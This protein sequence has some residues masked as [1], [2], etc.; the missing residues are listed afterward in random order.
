VRSASHWTREAR[1]TDSLGDAIA[2][3]MVVVMMTHPLPLRM[4]VC[5]SDVVNGWIGMRSPLTTTPERERGRE[6]NNEIGSQC[7]TETTYL[8]DQK[9]LLRRHLVFL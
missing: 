6:L 2:G 3:V 5:E 9:L 1:A 4:C 8:K 7:F